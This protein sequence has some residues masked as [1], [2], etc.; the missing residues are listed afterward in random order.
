MGLRTGRR[1]VARNV[2]REKLDPVSPGQHPASFS[3]E[4]CPPG[5]QPETILW[6]GITGMMISGGALG[7]SFA[8]SFTI[9]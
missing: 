3:N 7:L 9:S 1:G 6:K 4:K 5:T 2:Q 8:L